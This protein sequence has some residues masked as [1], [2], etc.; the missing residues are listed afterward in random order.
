[1][2]GLL[3]L[4][5]QLDAVRRLYDVLTVRDP[6]LSPETFP[7]SLPK[8]E[9]DARA[10]CADDR[11]L[12]ITNLSPFP[13][14]SQLDYRSPVRPPSLLDRLRGHG[15]LRKSTIGFNPHNIQQIAEHEAMFDALADADGA[16]LFPSVQW[17]ITNGSWHRAVDGKTDTCW[18]SRSELQRDDYFGLH[19]VPSRSLE[20]VTLLGSADLATQ[21]WELWMLA[22]EQDAQWQRR[23]FGIEQESV[24]RDRSRFKLRL[25][26]DEARVRKFKL[27]SLDKT[28]PITV[29]E[30][31]VDDVT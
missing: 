6:Y 14:P 12:F 21:S 4:T 11:C 7:V 23:R 31:Y 3:E 10:P 24:E 18:H 27:V 28:A 8:P 1:M 22:D 19:L 26:S 17:F 15:K 16:K 25:A 30:V 5:T 20:L 29:C 13:S 9:H 2:L